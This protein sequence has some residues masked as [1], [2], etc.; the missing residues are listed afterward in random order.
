[1]KIFIST[2]ALGLLVISAKAQIFITQDN[3]GVSAPMPEKGTPEYIQGIY[4]YPDFVKGSVT[5]LDNKKIA[6]A[7]LIYDLSKDK[8]IFKGED[9][10]PY[11]FKDKVSEFQMADP[12]SGDQLIH[13]FKNGYPPIDR[14]SALNYYEVL[15]EGKVTL[16]KKEVRIVSETI[17]YGSSAPVKSVANA[18]LYYLYTN[19]TMTQIKK[20]KKSMGNLLKGNDFNL[21]K[22]IS[23]NNLNIK[24]DEDLVKII[25]YY[26]SI[27]K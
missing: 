4:L 7:D 9:N 20:D 2:V 26:N 11:W 3:L 14:Y 18:Q 16:L 19:D 21:T 22:Y 5:M 24:N 25:N 8:I 6:S 12:K 17:P 15:A 23:D 1:M 10:K 13:L 27:N